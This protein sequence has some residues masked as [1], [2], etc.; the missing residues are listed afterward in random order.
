MSRG[1]QGNKAYFSMGTWELRW[2]SRHSKRLLPL[3]ISDNVGSIL[4]TGPCHI[5]HKE[6]R[7]VSWG[8]KGNKRT[9]EI[10]PREPWELPHPQ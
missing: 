1:F 5:M 4:D 6:Q 10:F 8:N 3:S 2:C 9:K 7:N